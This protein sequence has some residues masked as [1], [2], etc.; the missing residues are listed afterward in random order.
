MKWVLTE[1]KKTQNIEEVN[2]LLKKGWRYFDKYT[3]LNEPTTIIL[4]RY[5]SSSFNQSHLKSSFQESDSISRS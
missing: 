3:L 4:A 2:E 5:E 1:I